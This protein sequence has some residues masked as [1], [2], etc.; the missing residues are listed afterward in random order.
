MIAMRM[1]VILILSGIFIYAAGCT[2]QAG[3]SDFR[4]EIELTASTPGDSMIKEMLGIDRGIQVDFIRWNLRLASEE[5]N[6]K[7]F[8]LDINFGESQP[9]TS[10]FIMGGYILALRGI[11]TM[12]K[13][14]NIE[15]YNLRSTDPAASFSL[16]RLTGDL[17]HLLT[18]DNT[19]M[20]GNGGWSY[21]LNRKNPIRS[22][23]PGQTPTF[24]PDVWKDS[25]TKEIFVGRTPCTPVSEI[26]HLPVS[27]N[28]IK[29]KWKLTLYRD[30]VTLLPT[31]YSLSRT[32]HREREVEGRWTILQGRE[33]NSKGIIYQL[34]PDKSDISLFFLRADENL[35]FFLD[36]EFNPL[37]GDHNFSY[38]LNKLTG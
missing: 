26:Y 18:P 14:N 29:L 24:F 36:K 30:P 7:S 37:V 17:Y 25:Q 8:V 21:T 22:E 34:D 11:Y 15:Y 3:K 4:N 9:N 12:V 20:V 32:G 33:I 1:S 10:G 31:S 16:V 13:E 2:T 19:L 23:E 5:N 6:K 35:L 27:N 38:T 28:C